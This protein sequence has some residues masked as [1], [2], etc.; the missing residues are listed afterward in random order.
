[1]KRSFAFAAS[2]LS[3]LLLVAATLATP[4]AAAG[5]E[6]GVQKKFT[7][8][9]ADAAVQSDDEVVAS[10]G[11]A[12][13][14]QRVPQAIT[15]EPKDDPA[16]A[17]NDDQV[18]VADAKPKKPDFKSF[19]VEPQ[20]E[21][22]A[23]LIEDQAA[24]SLEDAPLPKNKPKVLRVSDEEEAPQPKK[25]IIPKKPVVAETSNETEDEDKTLTAEE[26]EEEPTVKT[27]EI[28]DK[29]ALRAQH[30]KPIRYSEVLHRYI[31]VTDENLAYEAAAYQEVSAHTP[32]YRYTYRHGYSSNDLPNCED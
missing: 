20:D 25:I 17:A 32:T 12:G 14:S 26:T 3:A 24:A 5:R 29:A 15:F 6:I 23:P 11:D 30:Y 28:T 16:A 13:P 22:T 4:A 21:A 31:E 9:A 2:S 10:N 7:I 8:D 18:D 27:A 1:M 19:T